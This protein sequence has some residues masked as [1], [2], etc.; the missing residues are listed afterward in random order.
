MTTTTR[1]ALL[2]GTIVITVCA[3]L[4][5]VA[6]GWVQRRGAAGQGTMSRPS[7]LV[8]AGHGG[9]DGGAVAA[10]G[11]MEKDLNLAISLSLRDLLTVMGFSVSLTRE[12]DTMVNAVGDTIRQRKVSD[13]KN[14]LAMIEQTPLTVSIHQNKFEQSQYDGT[15]VFYSGNHAHSAVIAEAVRA[16]V[17]AVLQPHNTRPLK[18]GTKDVYLL[19]HATT[20]MILVEC[21][22]LSNTAELQKLKDPVYQ[23]QLAFAITGGILKGR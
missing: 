3:L 23:R 8:D 4:L 1:T 20:P 14:R 9:D 12:T 18:K 16:S 22:F 13:M 2:D 5:T 11:T 10:D 21:G 7:V 15:Q 17:V 6:G 19:A